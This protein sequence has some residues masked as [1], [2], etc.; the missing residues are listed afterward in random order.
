MRLIRGEALW[1]DLPVMLIAGQSR[2][3]VAV[4]AFEAG[5]DDVIL[6]P[7]HFEV[8]LRGSIGASSAPGRSSDCATTMPRSTRRIVE[9]AIEIG[10]F[11]RRFLA[12]ECERPRLGRSALKRRDKLANLRRDVLA[13]ER[14]REI[15]DDEARLAA[16]IVAHRLDR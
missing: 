11:E 14:H 16:A 2:P 7:F 4:R 3:A 12:S 10:E 5:A 8:L 13:L 1:R 9:R 6:K 15:G